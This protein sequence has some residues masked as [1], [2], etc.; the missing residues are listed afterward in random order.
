MFSKKLEYGY[1]I[2]K[3]L[4][5]TSEI[6]LKSGKEIVE[7]TKVPYN[8]GLTILTELS[9]GKLIKSV[10]GKNGGFYRDKREITLLDLF[11]VLENK[12]N[13]DEFKNNEYKQK[14]LKIGVYILEKMKEIKV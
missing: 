14:I 11:K 3:A 6:T 7:E 2:V 12:K 9:T 5:N 13:I 8:M 10:K 4:K 1:L